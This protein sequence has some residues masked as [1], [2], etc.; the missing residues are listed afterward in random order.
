M[1]RFA[2]QKHQTNQKSVEFRFLEHTVYNRHCVYN[3]TLYKGH[4]ILK[5]S[6]LWQPFKIVGFNFLFS[7]TCESHDVTQCLVLVL[8]HTLRLGRPAIRWYL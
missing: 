3:I 1:I 8:D 5:K 2:L 4:C 6:K 7:L